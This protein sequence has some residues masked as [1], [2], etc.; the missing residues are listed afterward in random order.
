MM[1]HN[2]ATM[3]QDGFEGRF[4]I[5]SDYE[6][7]CIIVLNEKGEQSPFAKAMIKWVLDNDCNALYFSYGASKGEGGI[8]DFPI[9]Q[10]E[11]ALAW[12]HRKGVRKIGIMGIGYGGNL[13]LTAACLL[14]NI[15]LTI[16]FSAID[17]VTEGFT[18]KKG[19]EVPAGKS[20]YSW[21]G[22]EIPWQPFYLKG[23]E[24]KQLKLDE[25][26]K[27]RE[28]RSLGI[29]RSMEQKTELKEGVMLPIEMIQGALYIFAAADDSIW[30]SAHFAWRIKKR[31]EEKGSRGIYKVHIYRLGT[32]LL[33]PESMFNLTVPLA[34]QL[35]TKVFQSGRKHGKEC[36][37]NREDVDEKIRLAIRKWKG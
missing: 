15:T 7:T 36:R 9:D 16:A 37:K 14:S 27:Y 17:F 23:E 18:G 24:H 13:A 33:I 12:L 28:L 34:G 31:L 22:E 29:Y 10:V 26:R 5:S 35:M 32:H 2:K 20:C 21:R 6:Q 4:Y 19:S 11:C 30:D 8:C 3:E 1:N 25:S